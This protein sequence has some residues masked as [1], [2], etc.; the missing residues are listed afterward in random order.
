[1]NSNSLKTTAATRFAV[2]RAQFSPVTH[3][4]P[5]ASSARLFAPSV[6]L[7]TKSNLRAVPASLASTESRTFPNLWSSGELDRL[8]PEVTRYHD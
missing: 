6:R 2:S 7:L 3:R 8:Q 5:A 4:T 1:M